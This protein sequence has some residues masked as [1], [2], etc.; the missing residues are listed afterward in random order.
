MGGLQGRGAGGAGQGRGPRSTRDLRELLWLQMPCPPRW[1]I[2]DI[3]RLCLFP[4]LQTRLLSSFMARSTEKPP[5]SL[6]WGVS[7]SRGGGSVPT[8][9]LG[10]SW[11]SMN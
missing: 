3:A 1:A 9:L 5:E 6:A 7:S 2:E 8:S 10:V 11:E 4:S